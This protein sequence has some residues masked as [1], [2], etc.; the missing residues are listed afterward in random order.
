MELDTFRRRAVEDKELLRTKNVMLKQE[1][2]D[3]LKENQKLGKDRENLHTRMSCIRSQNK[4]NEKHIST[5]SS[6]SQRASKSDKWTEQLEQKLNF[7]VVKFEEQ[8]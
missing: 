6:P 4:R 2:E 7:T 5:L 1:I 3:L 8:N